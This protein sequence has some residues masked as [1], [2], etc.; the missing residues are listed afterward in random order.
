MGVLDLLCVISQ[1]GR[2]HET[3]KNLDRQT[4]QATLFL[5][6]PVSRARCFP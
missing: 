1:W 6:E 4:Q 2:W 5:P 3:S